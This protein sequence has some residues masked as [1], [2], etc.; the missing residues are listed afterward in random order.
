MGKYFLTG[1]NS[2][3]LDSNAPLTCQS[4]I[5]RNL[6][7][8]SIFYLRQ[9]SFF[10]ASGGQVVKLFDATVGATSPTATAYR[11]RD[12]IPCATDERTVI[13]YPEP[14]LKFSYGVGAIKDSTGEGYFGAGSVMGAG[15][16][17]K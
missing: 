5:G 17:V 15:Y 3:A 6:P 7:S 2:V 8:K 10:N 16:L 1:V 11:L 12:T 4:A 9:I 14:G 13:D